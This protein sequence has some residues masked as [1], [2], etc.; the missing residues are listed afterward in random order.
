MTN[1]NKTLRKIRMAIQ[2]KD[3]YFALKQGDRYLLFTQA[4]DAQYE[5]IKYDRSQKVK[6]IKL[7]FNIGNRLIK[8]NKAV[9]VS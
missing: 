8:Q 6:Y 3:V 2:S 9:L 7:P 4:I 1:R 5:H